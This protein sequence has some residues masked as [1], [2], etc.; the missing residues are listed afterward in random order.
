MFLIPLIR[1][2][3]S[4]HYAYIVALILL[5]GKIMTTYSY[6]TVKGLVYITITALFSWQPSSYPKCIKLNIHSSCNIQLVS[7]DEYIYYIHFS[8]F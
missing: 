1:S 5:L 7:T 3:T 6:Y 4:E 2:L 8:T